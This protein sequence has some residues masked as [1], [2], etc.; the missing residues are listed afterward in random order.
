[1]K[2]ARIYAYGHSDQIHIDEISQPAPRPREVLVRI[3][4]A[5]VNPI[6]WKIREGYMAKVSPRTFPFTL[7]QDF[8]GDVVAVGWDVTGVEVGDEVYGF[9]D[10]AYAEYACVSPEMIARKPRS[11]SDAVAAALPTPGLT[12]LQ[13]V[14]RIVDP[15]PG[16]TVL[17]HGAAGAVG[18]IAT[19]LCLGRGAHVIATA[20]AR[21]AAYLMSLGVDRVI[22]YATQRFEDEA[23]RV[24]AVI[25]LVGGETYARSLV[26]LRDGGVIVTIVGSSAP[27]DGK[28][29]RAVAHV[30][31]KNR[32]DL[33]ELAQLVDHGAIR[34]R[35]T[36]ALP[37]EAVREAQDLSQGRRSPEKLVLDLT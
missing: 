4:D 23:R 29:V 2:A 17:I 25:D 30:M 11:V 27:K 16:E 13:L 22:D 12:A 8:C 3:S 6:D 37:L 28:P 18:S 20:S 5:G 15:K 31:T 35:D 14:T 21:D 32:V 26:S 1:M 9:A 24:D 19:Q 7:G 36:R 33:D 10:G 34:P